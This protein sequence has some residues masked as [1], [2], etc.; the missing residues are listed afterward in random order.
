MRSFVLKLIKSLLLLFSFSI[1]TTPTI[2]KAQDFIWLPTSLVGA[3][4]PRRAYGTVWT[5]S[6]MLVWGGF[7]EGWVCSFKTGGRYNPITDTWRP[8]STINAPSPRRHFQ[9]VWSGT[10]MLVWTGANES[11]CPDG[12]QF[13]ADGGRYNPVTDTWTPISTVNAPSPRWTTGAVWTG[14]EMIVWGGRGST[15]SEPLLNRGARYNPITDTWTTMSN[16]GAPSPR[17]T[18]YQ[19]FW[20]GSELIVWGGGPSS[21]PEPDGAIY[22]PATDSWRPMNSGDPNAG[23]TNYSG[24]WTGS[25]LVTWSGWN[26]YNVLV[27]TGQIYNPVT[28]TWRPMTTLNSP[29]ARGLIPTWTGTELFIWGG[30]VGA[31]W[32]DNGGLYNPTTDTWRPT[33]DLNNLSARGDTFPIWTGNEVI[34]WGGALTTYNPWHEYIYNTGARFKIHYNSP[35]T[36]SSGGPYSVNEGD[37]V[38]L[39][40]NGSDPDNDTLSYTWDLDNNGTFETSGQTV[41]FSAV[42]LDGPGI[43]NV[44]VKVTDGGGLTATD[45]TSIDI[46]NVQPTV[47]SINAPLDPVLINTAINT[48]GTFTDPSYSDLHTAIWD[49][50]D[51]F[52][53][54]GN[55]DELYNSVAASHT[56]L[57]PGVYEIKLT[58]T[59][60]DS[61]SGNLIYQYVVVYDSNV[62]GGFVTGA[63]TIISPLGAYTSDYSMTGIARFG[64]ISKY[65]PG[66][67]SPTGTTQFRFQTAKFDFASKDYQWLVVAGA[68]AK[69]K[70]TGTVNG[71][72]NYGFQISATDGLIQGGG[73]IDKFRIKIWDLNNNNFVVYDNQLGSNDNTNPTTELLGGNIVIH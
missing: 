33:S 16:V 25:E 54:E 13:P 8:I 26:K 42:N 63:G 38:D 3:P 11:F 35:P 10:E 34:V 1:F 66:A 2:I 7:P 55:V 44:A 50:G 19:M 56:Y 41:S 15:L 60:D 48:S 12:A 22:N 9:A 39:T 53:S 24:A 71:S 21:S 46:L 73:D 29:A 51:G 67:S 36:V 69:F 14:T 70:G 37:S 43:S 17:S 28:D 58:A 18:E 6:E 45:Q 31:N 23:F 52:S 30:V 65:Q 49:W 20:T 32:M 57:T 40:A 72:G 5:G 27:Q 61:G 64:F 59:D 4:T 47:I 62:N 68:Q